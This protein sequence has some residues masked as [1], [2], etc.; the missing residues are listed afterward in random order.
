MNTDATYL[1]IMSTLRSRQNYFRR[2]AAKREKTYHDIVKDHLKKNHKVKPSG[3]Y[4]TDLTVA[5]ELDAGVIALFDG[6]FDR[7]VPPISDYKIVLSTTNSKPT[8]IDIGWHSSF[9]L[10]V[11]RQQAKLPPE[12][13]N[14]VDSAAFQEFREYIGD[15]SFGVGKYANSEL[16]KSFNKALGDAINKQAQYNA[17][18]AAK[19]VDHVKEQLLLSSTVSAMNNAIDILNSN[20]LEGWASEMEGL[21]NNSADIRQKLPQSIELKYATL[22]NVKNKEFDYYY[23]YDIPLDH[24]ASLSNGFHYTHSDNTYMRNAIGHNQFSEDDLGS[25]YNLSHW[26]IDA[27][28][29]QAL[30]QLLTE[31][32]GT[33]LLEYKGLASQYATLVTH[34]LGAQSVTWDAVAVSQ[35][36]PTFNT[37]DRFGIAPGISPQK[38]RELVQDYINQKYRI[39]MDIWSS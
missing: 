20:I 39:K 13:I 17:A 22:A 10:Q 36:Q 30:I 23:L 2:N 31:A 21:L 5:L 26:S 18:L 3:D 38:Y 15:V 7:P 25:L 33:S 4:I 14:L 32:Y 9:Q 11:I 1:N 37:Q 16:S 6:Y 8:Q 34:S 12:Y 27:A 28:D 35:I 29:A 19:N 24:K